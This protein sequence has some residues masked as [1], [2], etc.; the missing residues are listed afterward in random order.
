MA[1]SVVL[2]AHVP[3]RASTD[4]STIFSEGNRAYLNGD[5]DQAVAQYR[6]LLDSGVVD[7]DVYYNLA[8]AYY[9]QGR[10]GLAILFYEKALKL[11]PGD[12]A[13][14][15]N[16]DAARRKLVD[17][18]EAG[19]TSGEPGWHRLLGRIAIDWLTWPLLVLAWVCSVLGVARLLSR[20]EARKRM[21][22]W[23]NLPLLAITF[24]CGLVFTGRLYLHRRVHYGIVL[25]RQVRLLEGPDGKA[26]A[27]VELHEGLKVRLLV[28]AGGY[29]RV[30]L[31]NGVEGYLPR[32]S[33]GAI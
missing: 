31:A 23:I 14:R 12:E 27:V 29:V 33:V 26:A 2:L 22:K 5:Y 32:D 19:G 24:C 18:L 21:L 25:D 3:A 20:S 4:L 10:L 6:K 28:D 30:R 17:K 8:N 9:R 7:A 15:Y 16:L 1:L 11:S 13:A